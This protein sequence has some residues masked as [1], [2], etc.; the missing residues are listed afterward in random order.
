MVRIHWGCFQGDS[1]FR[2]DLSLPD[3]ETIWD[4]NIYLLNSSSSFK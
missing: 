3:L 1:E 2:F 4:G